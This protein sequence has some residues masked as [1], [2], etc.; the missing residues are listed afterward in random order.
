LRNNGE[1]FVE[2]F[3]LTD[4]LAT[5]SI[6]SLLEDREGNLW[7]GTGS[8]GLHILRVDRSLYAGKRTRQRSGESA[9]ESAAGHFELTGMRE[10]AAAMGRSLEVTS[11]SGAGTTVRLRAPVSIEMRMPSG[12]S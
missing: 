11:H 4:P 5:A 6:L 8:M 9:A 7:V 1:R 3:P 2:R 10:R 12:E